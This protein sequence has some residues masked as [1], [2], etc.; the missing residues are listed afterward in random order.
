MPTR[1]RP[2]RLLLVASVAVLGLLTGCTSHS[3]RCSGSTCTVNLS[4]AQVV[5]VD[6]RADWET[7]LQVG[8]IEPAAVTVSGYDGRVRLTPGTAAEVSGFRAE[9]LPV[10][11][12]DVSL[13]VDRT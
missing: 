2:A 6:P 4:G 9:L 1:R 11:G 10:S 7:D 12:R 13:R 5:D 8:P 3:T